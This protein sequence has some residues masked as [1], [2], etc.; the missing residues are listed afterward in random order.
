MVNFGP[1]AAEIISLVW[2]T[3]A[4]FNGFRVLAA[5]LHYTLLVG[6]SQ[7]AALNRGRHL[8]SVGRPSRWALAHISS[9]TSIFFLQVFQTCSSAQNGSNPS[10]SSFKP[11]P[12]IPSSSF[13][14]HQ[15]TILTNTQ[16][17]E[18]IY[19]SHLTLSVLI[20]PE[21]NFVAL[22]TFITKHVMTK[23]MS[24]WTIFGAHFHRQMVI[25]VRPCFA[26]I[27]IWHKLQI[28]RNL[29]VSN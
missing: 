10:A 21:I 6:I 23:K 17:A 12:G 3:P 29:R 22:F 16:K 15:F 25:R 2:G 19:F 7:T 9:C 26:T 24:D 20:Q 8:Y 28:Q 14:C 18:D 13:Y 11:T 4:N 1:L 27:Y 5:L